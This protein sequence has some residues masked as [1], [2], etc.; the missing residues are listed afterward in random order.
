[1]NDTEQYDDKPEADGAG[2]SRAE[3][4]QY[5]LDALGAV[6]KEDEN[7]R[8]EADRAIC[9]YRGET[10]DDTINETAFNILHSNI[11]TTLPAIYNSTPVPDVRRRFGDKD[12]V[13]KTVSQILERCLSYSVDNYDFDEVMRQCLFDG[14]VAGR[15]LARVR[16]VPY[17]TSIDGTPD[18]DE[19]RQLAPEAPESGEQLSY[20]EVICEYV[21]WRRFRAGPADDW[22]SVPW[23]A[24]E[25]MLTR[26]EA[27][28]LVDGDEEKIKSINFSGSSESNASKESEVRKS[29]TLN[30]GCVWEIWDKETRKV[31]FI[32]DG[33]SAGPLREED[34]PLGLEGFFPVPRPVQQILTPGNIVPVCPY[35][36]YRGLVEELNTVSR[37]ITRLVKQ[38][39]VRGGYASGSA[40]LTNIMNADDGEVVP[41][42]GMEAWL[43]GGIDKAITWWPIEPA[44]KA[45]AQLIAH[46]EQVKQTIYEVTGISDIVRG[47]SKASETAT[48]QEI[49]SQWGSLRIQKMQG[50]VQRFARDLFR[51]KAEVIATKFAPETIMMT[52]GIR[53]LP[54][55]VKAQMQMQAQQ[56]PQGSP[57]PQIPEEMKQAMQEP[58]L[59]AV[60]AVMRSD[61]MRA[62][63]I[64]IE[65]DSTIRAD[66]TRNQTAMAGFLQGTAQYIGA[67][68]PAVQ[69]GQM[70][71]QVAVEIYS[72]FARNYKLGKQ[73]QDALEKMSEAAAKPK[74]PKPDPD[75][76]KAKMEM[77]IKQQDAQASA[78]L[79]QRKFEMQAAHDQSKA[80]TDMALAQ[81]RMQFDMDLAREKAAQEYNLRL[82]E[83]QADIEIKRETA[84]QQSAINAETARAKSTSRNSDGRTYNGASGI[85][86]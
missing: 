1:M 33:Y 77:Q 28:K 85:S 35:T 4:V 9:I 3:F 12:T 55:E 79:E 74:P 58:A 86:Q 56:A 7:W 54:G 81:Q 63:R 39:R 22:A 23:V 48:A 57:T 41:L 34:D 11:E 45:L 6:T 71:S 15:G 47:A 68:G 84:I 66:L 17:F 73:A 78:M 62:Y 18:D 43:D 76:E 49:K 10:S 80:Q 2:R 21:P 60:M 61:M 27:R 59:E 8:K 69:S 70:D 83:T 37:R 26:E 20:E 50:E 36:I 52:T 5:W 64:D 75:V 65:S 32:T 67:V 46:R 38:I 25:H 42:Q 13:A 14:H 24:F 72:S 30:R 44:V 40:D 53:L 29:D 19:S 16:Y 51:M 31:I 82:M